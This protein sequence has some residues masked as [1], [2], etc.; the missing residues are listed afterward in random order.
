M[1]LENQL[2]LV[3][4]C[5]APPSSHGYPGSLSPAELWQETNQN[6]LL[7]WIYDTRGELERKWVGEMYDF[8]LQPVKSPLELLMRCRNMTLQLVW[9][10]LWITE[11]APCSHHLDR[12]SSM[13]QSS[14]V[15]VLKSTVLLAMAVI[16]TRASSHDCLRATILR[17]AR[18][19]T[20]PVSSASSS[21][22]PE[23]EGV[24]WAV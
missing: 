2:P 6:G 5:S 11:P 9:V 3:E 15:C 16:S 4:L 12:V 7:E 1:L 17:L 20:V 21:G 13:F 19:T 22:L 23:M 18:Q 24:C 14:R 10:T 8:L